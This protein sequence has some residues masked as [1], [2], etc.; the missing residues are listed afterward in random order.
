MIVVEKEQTYDGHI[1]IIQITP[2]LKFRLDNVNLL[3]SKRP[4]VPDVR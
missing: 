1:K 2:T 3:E 4:L